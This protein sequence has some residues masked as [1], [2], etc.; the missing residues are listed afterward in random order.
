MRDEGRSSLN[1]FFLRYLYT[2]FVLN[3]TTLFSSMGSRE[4][5]GT[6]TSAV[7]L[8]LLVLMIIIAYVLVCSKGLVRTCQVPRNVCQLNFAVS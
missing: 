8:A 7:I 6:R 2:I 1:S 4:G 3:Y 5:N